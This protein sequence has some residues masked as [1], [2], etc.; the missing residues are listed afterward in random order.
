M[1]MRLPHSTARR[2]ALS[3]ASLALATLP[4][5]PLPALAGDGGVSAAD[6]Q[7][8]SEELGLEA[9]GGLKPGTGRPLNALIK[10]RS[11]TGVERTG[12]VENSL[13]KPGQVFDELRCE[14]G[15]AEIAFAFPPNCLEIDASRTS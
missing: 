11:A 12:S 15:V 3:L 1:I 9:A 10:M 2:D 13:F 14:R 8:R 6:A 7:R 5:V 4:S